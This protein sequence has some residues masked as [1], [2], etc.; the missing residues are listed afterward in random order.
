M[1]QNNE[2][3]VKKKKKARGLLIAGLIIS[4]LWQLLTAFATFAGIVIVVF[5]EILV[6]VLAALIGALA[7]GG[8]SSASSSAANNAS[9][10]SSLWWIIPLT[11]FLA[12]SA[13]V[14]M[15]L[16]IVA[17]V[18]F[19]TAKTK[20]KGIIAGILAIVSGAGI[21][22]IPLELIG[23]IMALQLGDKEYAYRKPK[24]KKEQDE[25]GRTVD[26]EVIDLTNNEEGK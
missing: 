19:N 26:N 5:A 25:E 4:V 2:V 1:E 21:I 18:L 20:K 10:F 11:L 16:A 15:V 3:N 23:G 24:R 13:F 14:I 22:F 7:S 6:K 8:N 9:A 12:L 17:L